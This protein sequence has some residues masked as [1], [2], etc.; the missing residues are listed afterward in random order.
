MGVAKM[1]LPLVSASRLGIPRGSTQPAL[2]ISDPWICIAE[3]LLETSKIW[4]TGA[5]FLY[6]VPSYIRHG[7]SRILGLNCP[8]FSL[9]TG[10]GF[11]AGKSKP[12]MPRTMI[13]A[14]PPTQN[15]TVTLIEMGH[16]PWLQQQNKEYRIS[17]QE[18]R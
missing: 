2:P 5:L 16:C 13:P 8:H 15:W 7:S 1:G 10:L 18:R 14:Q 6:P 11:H 12:G 4:R 9:L 3:V 17:T